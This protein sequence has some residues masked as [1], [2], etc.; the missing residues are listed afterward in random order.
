MKIFVFIL[1]ISIVE[2]VKSSCSG[3]AELY[4][5]S[6]DK[7]VKKFQAVLVKFDTQFPYGEVHETF[8]AFADEVNNKT[9]SGA[10]HEDFLTGV[11]GW[12]DY[13]DAN[14]QIICER[15]GLTK[16]KD[17]P[18]ILLFVDGDLVNPIDF[19]FGNKNN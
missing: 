15:Y 2:L 10:E 17:F 12:K 13:G 11:V 7:I 3:C 18:A 8:S 4:D 14:N 6:F 5:L 1:L 19:K 9:K 16:R